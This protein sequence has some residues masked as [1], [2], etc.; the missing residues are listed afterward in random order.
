MADKE[1]RQF[2]YIEF[3]AQTTPNFKPVRNGDYIKYGDNNDYDRYIIDLYQRCAE[4][5]A[6][7]NSK[8]NF[9]FGKGLSYHKTNDPATDAKL[10]KFISYANRY[11]SWNDVLPQSILSFE[12]IDGFY[13]QYIFG[14]NGKIVSAYPMDITR[15]RRSNDCKGFW[16]CEDWNDKAKVQE[17][18][19]YPEYSEVLKTGSCIYYCK[20]HKPAI[21]RYGDVYSIPNYIGALNAIETDINIDI[22]FNALTKNGMTAQGMLTLPNGEPAGDEEAKE[23][24]KQFRK[25]YQGAKNAGGIMLNF[26]DPD[27][28]PAS[29]QN[30]STSDLDKQFEILSKRNIQ[31]ITSGHR[32]D[33]VLIGI[34]T[35]TSWSRPDLIN[36]WERFN[37]EY[38]RIRQEK[39][40]E[41]VRI[42][43]ESQGVAVDQLY[44]EPLPPIGEELEIT[45]STLKDILTVPELRAYVRDKKGIELTSLDEDGSAS[46]LSVAQKLGV[47]GSTALQ[48]LILDPNVDSKTKLGIMGGMYSIPDKKARKMLGLPE[49]DLAELTPIKSSK[50][51]ASE[52]GVGGVTALSVILADPNNTPEQ[53]S[54]MAQIIFGIEKA[55]ADRLAGVAIVTPVAM[56]AHSTILDRFKELA[57]DGNDDEVIDEFYVDGPVSQEYFEEVLGGTVKQVRNQILDLLAGDPYIKL[58]IIAKQ[59]GTDVDYVTEQITQLKEQGLLDKNGMTVKGMNRADKV[60]P[61][62]E[63]EIYTVYQ[64][65]LSPKADYSNSKG[66]IDTSHEF[67]IEMM[68]LANAGKTWTREAIDSITND[69]GENAWV[70]RGGP[71]GRKGGG[72]TQFCNHIFKAKIMRRT[73]N[74]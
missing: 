57:Q 48:S 36:K 65:A 37:T 41:V 50:S 30:F 6:I 40:M 74:A 60:E 69:F 68:K 62:I 31:K 17:K 71:T 26:I 43:G 58:E 64:Y 44:F 9:V 8:A 20:V 42:M 52:I 67:C 51:L 54:N 2:M 70:Y 16:Y 7:I 11:G 27:G 10:E 45:E 49:V 66:Y 15:I 47:G 23:I 34:D 19:Y 21:N 63:T 73:R 38:V 32:I 18:K 28:N 53:K 55:E 39:V 13:I 35:A 56:S 22:F 24:E 12:M 46:R 5:N 72:F 14:K 25:K 3:E 33:P 4:N 59:L 29:F 1:N 61:V